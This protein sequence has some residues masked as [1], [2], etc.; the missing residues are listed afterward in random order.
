MGLPGEALP[1]LRGDVVVL[2]LM[3]KA[4]LILLLVLH[5]IEAAAGWRAAAGETVVS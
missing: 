2:S 5:G 1:L 4:A 3:G